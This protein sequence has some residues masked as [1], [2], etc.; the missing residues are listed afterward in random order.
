[1]QSEKPFKTYLINLD[2]AVDRFKFMDSQLRDI[3]Y[4]L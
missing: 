3:G 4:R 2:R 1:M